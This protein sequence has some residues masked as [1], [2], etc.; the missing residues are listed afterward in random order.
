VPSPGD[1]LDAVLE[2]GFELQD[3]QMLVDLG[4]VQCQVQDGR[5]VV[6]SGEGAEG[7]RF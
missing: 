7:V 6:V 4:L 2:A 5:I 1:E 3:N